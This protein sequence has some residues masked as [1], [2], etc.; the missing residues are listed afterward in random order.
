[1]DKVV[2]GL[3]I[4]GGLGI[5]TFVILGLAALFLGWLCS[6]KQP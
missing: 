2:E 4:I 1:M 5:L 3:A 6:G